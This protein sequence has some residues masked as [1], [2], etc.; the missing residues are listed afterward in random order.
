MA[1][2][3]SDARV[4]TPSLSVQSF[5]SARSISPIS[6]GRP[7]ET[8]SATAVINGSLLEPS[9]RAVDTP[10]PQP[11]EIA[12]LLVG[13]AGLLD[14]IRES[15]SDEPWTVAEEVKLRAAA[16]RVVPVEWARQLILDAG[17]AE[18][19]PR[20]VQLKTRLRNLLHRL[21]HLVDCIL[22]DTQF[23]VEIFAV[24]S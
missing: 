19:A 13:R 3:M 4:F 11:Q 5:L 23:S 15:V 7:N 22:L 8:F 2:L 24:R 10:L 16:L 20:L 1:R 17:A 21:V 18:A 9:D 6:T 12:D 14:R